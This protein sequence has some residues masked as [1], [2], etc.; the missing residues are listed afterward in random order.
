MT[1]L[2]TAKQAIQIQHFLYLIRKEAIYSIALI[3]VYKD[4]QGAI[5]LA[6]NP[7]NY[8]KTKY[9]TIHYHT[10]QKYIA[11]S[12]IQLKYILID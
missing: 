5:K 10:I 12:E 9:I 2:E 4:N 3:I 6:N 7:V 1:I 8:S 11:N